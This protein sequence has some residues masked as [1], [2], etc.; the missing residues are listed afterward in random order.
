MIIGVI[1]EIM[2][3]EN[4]VAATPAGVMSFVAAGHTV[5]VEKDAGLGSGFTDPEYERAGAEIIGGADDIYAAAD[6]IYKVKEPLAREYGYLRE[7]QIL[8]TYLHLAPDPL[9]TQALMDSGITAFAYETVQL[10]N[11]ALPLLAPMSEIAGKMSIQ[12]GANMLQKQNHGSGILLGGLPGV[13]PGNVVIVG[14][15]IAGTSAARIA[16]GL[17]AR[18]T[19]LDVSLERLAYLHDILPDRVTTLMSNSY[20]I[21]QSV[22]DADLLIGAVLIPGAK[23]PRLVTEEMVKSMRPGSVI[24]DISIDQGGMVETIDHTTS[25]ENPFFIKH[26]V[27]HYSVP[28][29]PGAVPR[30]STFALSNATLP[31]ALKLAGKGALQAMR[32]SSALLKGLSVYRGKVVSKAVAEAQGREYAPFT[33]DD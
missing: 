17:G 26:G 4:R 33:F 11:G 3:Q 13:A 16:C 23:A 21:A 14:G 19:V 18:V 28:N 8:F 5:Y 30:T 32:E 1:K 27:V 22:A 15:G 24:V 10:E 29:I 2:A 9:Q 25:H 6:M 31:Y 12:I 7:G 20:S